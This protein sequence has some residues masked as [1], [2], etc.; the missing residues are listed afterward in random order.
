VIQ[1]DAILKKL[2]FQRQRI[3]KEKIH[4]EDRFDYA[5]AVA[6]VSAA[7][8]DSF[9]ECLETLVD[10]QSSDLVRTK[11]LQI[12][13][14]FGAIETAAQGEP[15]FGQTALASLGNIMRS[16]PELHTLFIFQCLKEP[17]TDIVLS[18]SETYLGFIARELAVWTRMRQHQLELAE[19][20]GACAKKFA[21]V[22]Q[23]LLD[24]VERF[25]EQSSENVE[26]WR[27]HRDNNAFNAISQ[28]I[29]FTC[30]SP[31]TARRYLPELPIRLYT[32][33]DEFS[34]LRGVYIKNRWIF[35]PFLMMSQLANACPGIADFFAGPVWDR[36]VVEPELMRFY[37]PLAPALINHR[38]MKHLLAQLSQLLWEERESFGEP[39]VMAYYVQTLFSIVRHSAAAAKEFLTAYGQQRGKIIESQNR[40]GTLSFFAVQILQ[41]ALEFAQT[42]GPLCNACVQGVVMIC[43]PTRG[44][45][46]M[47]Q[48]LREEMENSL[49][50]VVRMLQDICQKLLTTTADQQSDATKEALI[51]VITIMSTYSSSARGQLFNTEMVKNYSR[52][53]I[54]FRVLST[55]ATATATNF[56]DD[57][58]R[59]A[60]AKCL[61]ALSISNF[62][63]H[64]IQ[65]L[66]DLFSSLPLVVSSTHYEVM[67]YLTYFMFKM[68][69][70][71]DSGESGR[72]NTVD[73]SP[74]K[75]FRSL[76]APEISATIFTL[77]ERLVLESAAE[78]ASYWELR[79]MQACVKFLMAGVRLSFIHNNGIDI[80][81]FMVCFLLSCQILSHHI[82]L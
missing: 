79:F 68:A 20:L 50:D 19:G 65:H 74:G 11:V 53:Q 3:P 59:L 33:M 5:R 81:F 67:C 55:E 28:V 44:H 32:K 62:Q 71:E 23:V 41:R 15:P 66:L 2:R 64:G 6:L 16:S 76:Y 30:K 40:N 46:K 13:V 14:E 4:D 12:F 9:F 58:V 37:E 27:N 57:D 80:F 49:S 72:G 39:A 35:S 61:V 17:F 24:R 36:K 22:H 77:L 21:K 10:R 60:A 47:W 45:E 54:I 63:Q 51:G 8:R 34:R 52:E 25:W 18:M 73:N 75:V 43:V 31:N 78:H 82:F 38:L 56:I 70:H 29:T 7:V 69:L 26:E 48:E 1:L 42:S